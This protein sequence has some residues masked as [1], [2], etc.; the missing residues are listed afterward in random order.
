[1]KI[2][3]PTDGGFLGDYAYSIAAKLASRMDVTLEY[4]SV[5]PTPGNIVFNADGTFVDDH[6]FDYSLFYKQKEQQAVTVQKWADTKEV[7]GNVEV[8]IGDVNATILSY[9][10]KINADLIIM[11]TQGV[12]SLKDSIHGSH[13]EYIAAHSKVPVISL[14]CDR[15][16][17]QLDEIV[18]VSDFE[19]TAAIEMSKVKAIATAFFSTIVLLKIVNDKNLENDI[20]LLQQM[21]EFAK[22]NHLKN[23]RNE[24]YYDTTVARGVSRFCEEESID[25]VAIGTHQKHGIWSLLH[26]S[27]SK[28]LVNH[29]YHPVLTFPL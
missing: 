11:G 5:I 12:F 8:L 23:Y 6:D 18:L 22:H 27:V 3:I 14:K 10:E 17:M 20:R 25:L 16:S 28:D 7:R 15:S 29:I 9:A 2:L 26:K 24:I 1:M 21:D 13:T 4:L 19:D